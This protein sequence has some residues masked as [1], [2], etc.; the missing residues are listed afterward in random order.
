MLCTTIPVSSYAVTAFLI[1]L[2]FQSTKPSP[3]AQSLFR[4]QALCDVGFIFLI[5]AVCYHVLRSLRFTLLSQKARESEI[6]SLSDTGPPEPFP[7]FDDSA[8][9]IFTIDWGHWLLYLSSGAIA[10]KQIVLWIIF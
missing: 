2:N 8:E 10:V 5:F 1:G 9:P 4:V 3:S 6:K 7:T